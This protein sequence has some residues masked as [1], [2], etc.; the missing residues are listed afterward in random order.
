MEIIHILGSS[1]FFDAEYYIKNHP[2][3][4]NGSSPIDSQDAAEHYYYHGWKEGKDPSEVFDTKYYLSMY[5]D[6]AASAM[7]P[8]LHYILIGYSEN[9]YTTRDMENIH[10]LG[11]SQ[12]FDAEYYLRNHPDS[13]DSAEHYYYHGWKE[14][15]NPSELFDTKYYLSMYEDVAA[16]DMN[17]L[18]HYILIGRSEE[19][20]PTKDMEVIAFLASSDLFDAEHYLK[21]NPEF[22]GGS[23]NVEK[24]DAAAHYYYHGW[25]EGRNPSE[26]FDTNYYLET[27]ED[28]GKAGVNP[29][30]HYL[31]SGH[32]EERSIIDSRSKLKDEKILD[33]KLLYDPVEFY[34]EEKIVSQLTDDIKL[35]AYHLPQFHRMQENDDWWGEGFTEWTNVKAAKPLFDRQYQPR[36][37]HDDIGYY[38]LTDIKSIKKQVELANNHGI[39]GFCFYYYWFSGKRLMEKP[40]DIILEHPEIKLNYCLCWANESWTKKWDGQENEILIK[41]EYSAENDI[42]FISDLSKYV[43]D[44]RYIRYNNKPVIL[45]YRADHLPEPKETTRRLR[46]WC[47]ENGIGEILLLTSFINEIGDPVSLGFDAAIERPF[48]NWEIGKI[49][50]RK[51][52]FVENEDHSGVVYTHEEAVDFYSNPIFSQKEF[53]IFR[54]LNAMWDPSSRHQDRCHIVH[55]AKPGEYQR[56]LDHTIV[57]TRLS[58]PKEERFVF[59]N[60]WNEW[61]EGTYLEPDQSFGY[62]MLNATGRALQPYELWINCVKGGGTKSYIDRSIQKS[63]QDKNHIVWNIHSGEAEINGH[64]N[65]NLNKNMNDVVKRFNITLIT[66]VS[67]VYDENVFRTLREVT[68]L[69]KENP[70]VNIKY[71]FHDYY[72]ICPSLNLLDNDMN[73]CNVPEEEHICLACLEYSQI[74]FCDEKNISLWRLAWKEML[75]AIDEIQVFSKSSLKIVAKTYPDLKGKV[76]LKPHNLDYLKKLRIPKIQMKSLH[77]GFLGDTLDHKGLGVLT[78][79]LPELKRQ[80]IPITI[81]GEKN[82]EVDSYFTFTGRYDLS[83]LPDIIEE[84]SVNVFLQVSICPETFCYTVA[85]L[86]HMQA[87]VICFDLGGQADLMKTYP[88]GKILPLNNKEKPESLLKSINQFFIEMVN[89]NTITTTVLF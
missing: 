22:L 81:I 1:Q 10:I 83:E 25:R 42:A 21:H 70:S 69:K 77:L 80:N 24:I 51:A 12:F 45:I 16:S 59:I 17:P 15:K 44:P 18:L 19:R 63:K 85:E 8:L 32:A 74:K 11:S 60:A 34:E 23:T 61:A 36:I 3:I 64:D 52:Q 35:I 57:D 49:R 55:L 50:N 30:W 78:S 5:E 65:I 46:R 13:Q 79:L 84:L 87:P 41:Q 75:D 53:K 31:S 39:Y 28:I 6:V 86:I 88:N 62:A 72:G 66:I 56:W 20:F 67:L 26:L 54:A 71:Q 40:I 43:Q 68:L 7:N 33:E 9:R 2:G 29:L 48:Y 89:S 58:S 47:R 14:G 27:Y 73:F 82:Q 37:P 76:I 38:D 4:K